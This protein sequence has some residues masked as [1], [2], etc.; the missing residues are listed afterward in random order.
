MGRYSE[1]YVFAV[2]PGSSL[3][4]DCI[5]NSKLAKRVFII[6]IVIQ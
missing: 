4:V 6:V 5:M 3:Q 1:M 2:T